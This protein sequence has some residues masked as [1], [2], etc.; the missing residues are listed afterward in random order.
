MIELAANEGR[1]CPTN[2]DIA[3]DLNASGI[4]KS[5]AAS[6][7]PSIIQRL[8]RRGLVTVRIYGHNWRDVMILEGTHAAKATL[9]PPHGGK[10]YIIIDQAERERRDKAA[11]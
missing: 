3:N 7:I 9:P 1:R 8:I 2:A 11:K 10:P 4:T 6:S 5:V